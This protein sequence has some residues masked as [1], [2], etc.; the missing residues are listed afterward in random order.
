MGWVFEEPTECKQLEVAEVMAVRCF[1]IVIVALRVLHEME[2][3]RTYAVEQNVL[4]V[5]RGRGMERKEI[6]GEE[7]KLKGEYR[8]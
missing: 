1:E 2:K 5:Q 3:P 6:A 4:G 7:L 8:S